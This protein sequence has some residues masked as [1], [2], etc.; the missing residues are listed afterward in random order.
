MLINILKIDLRKKIIASVLIFLAVILSL[1]FFIVI[2]T[3]KEIKRMGH[4]IEAQ[5]IDLETKFL[6][7]QNLKQLTK[8]LNEIEPNLIKLDQVFINQNK[9]LKFITTLEQIANANKV[10]Q[11]INLGDSQPL[12]NQIYKKVPVQLFT[13]GNFINQLNYLLELESLNYYLNIKSLELSPAGVIAAE[14]DKEALPVNLK[15]LISA[16]TYWK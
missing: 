5:R 15:M 12:E 14:A 3:V 10:G 16:D 6:K 11:K 7:G 2:P 1:I 13:Q 8:N 4:E 9:E